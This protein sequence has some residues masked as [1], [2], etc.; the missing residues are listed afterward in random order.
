MPSKA[1][2]Q[3]SATKGSADTK[4]DVTDEEQKRQSEESRKFRQNV[5]YGQPQPPPPMMMPPYG[6]GMGADET[7][8]RDE[9]PPVIV[10][11]YGAGA[12]GYDPPRL[13]LPGGPGPWPAPPPP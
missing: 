8:K 11:P 13:P 4:S 6:Y 12:G 1:S 2:P 10:P 5:P 9:T 7:Q 3:K